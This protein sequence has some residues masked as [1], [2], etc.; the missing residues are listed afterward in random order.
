MK[1]KVILG[2]SGGVDS[3][4]ALI[5]LLEQGYDVV[6]ITGK[7]TCSAEADEVV[8]NAKSVADKLGI[9]HFSVDV[10][11]EFDES[12]IKYFEES[13]KA[14][15]TPNP[16]IYI[17]TFLMQILPKMFIIIKKIKRNL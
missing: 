16:C 17:K 9:E 8:K 1:E 2:I 13:Y 12:V 10:S 7:M 14:G 4:V 11:K 3:S 15:K 6:G 5:K